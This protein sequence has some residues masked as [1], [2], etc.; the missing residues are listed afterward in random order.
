MQIKGLFGI[1]PINEPVTEPM[2]SI[3]NVTK[4]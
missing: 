2:W 1:T 3:M 4:R